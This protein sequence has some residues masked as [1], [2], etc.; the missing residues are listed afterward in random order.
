MYDFARGP[1]VYIA[2]VVM[3][4]GLAYR[5]FAAWKLAK[6]EKVIFPYMHGKYGLRSIWHWIVPFGSRNMRLRPTFTILSFLFHICLILVP[7]FTL[8]HAASIERTLG[9]QWLSLSSTLSH[10]MTILVVLGSLIFL[11]RRLAEPTVRLVSS[12]QDFVTLLIVVA[13]FATGLIARYQWFDYHTVITI[14]MIT[15]AIWLMAV[16]FTRIVHMLFFPF[17]RAYMGSEFGYV[18]NARDW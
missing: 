9:I 13:P 8:G 6:R 3:F 7:L 1:L 14:H 18:R 11:M 12:W 5:L 16:P 10:A 4:A 15:G 2:F 17:T